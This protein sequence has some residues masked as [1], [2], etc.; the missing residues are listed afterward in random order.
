MEKKIIFKNVKQVDEVDFKTKPSVDINRMILDGEIVFTTRHPEGVKRAER[1]S[2]IPKIEVNEEKVVKLN[3]C[4]H[5]GGNVV[6]VL[7]SNYD[8]D[9]DYY[10][11]GCKNCGM[12]TILMSDKESLVSMWNSY[13]ES[14]KE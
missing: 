1:I 8:P 6:E 9:Y 13:T 14:L 11:I 12:G 5:C 2:S 3:N 4:N 10:Y 7:K